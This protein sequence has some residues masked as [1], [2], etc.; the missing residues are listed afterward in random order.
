MPATK[1]P[2]RATGN[3]RTDPTPRIDKTTVNI[4]AKINPITTAPT[5]TIILSLQHYFIL[6]PEIDLNQ[7]NI[8]SS[9]FLTIF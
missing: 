7:Q 1:K 6:Y 9:I 2:T 4:I 3:P 5:L 8:I